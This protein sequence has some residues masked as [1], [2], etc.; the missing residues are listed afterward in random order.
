MGVSSGGGNS[1][2]DL[3]MIGGTAFEARLN[4]L[5]LAKQSLTDAYT[6]LGVGKSAKEAMEAA[7]VDKA[8][9]KKML[10]DADLT[11][12]K[13][14]KKTND[15]V[16]KIVARAEQAAEFKVAEA[17]A[18]V[19]GI[20]E[21]VDGMYAAANAALNQSTSILRDA[22]AVKINLD[23]K[24]FSLREIAEDLEAAKSEFLIAAEGIRDLQLRVR[25][26]LAL[27]LS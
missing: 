21:N 27:A 15:E 11:V 24:M 2:L 25:S 19:N 9:A 22:A 3:S 17:E 7:A 10:E 18:I 12:A 4:E 16:S 14:L 1:E 26:A 8:E 6:A 5:G 23:S 13:L 20:K